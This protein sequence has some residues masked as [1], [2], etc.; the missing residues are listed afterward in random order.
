MNALRVVAIMGLAFALAAAPVHHAP[1][2]KPQ[3][4]V[5]IVINGAPL[6]L[7]PRPLL[8]NG[9]LL[10]PVQRTI[11]AL[12]LDFEREG[13]RMI[14]HVGSKTVTLRDRSRIALVN[15]E[16]IVLDAPV[17]LLNDVFYAPLRF[18]TEVLGAQA[19]FSRRERTVTIVAQLVGRSGEG[20][21]VEGN[22]TL[23]VGTVTA[24]DVNSN[25]PTV[26][27]SF[28]G[29][30]RTIGITPNAI[31][32]MRDIA[33][34]V[35][36]PGELAD[37]HPGDYAEITI[38]KDGTVLSV[39]DAFG[40]RYGTIAATNDSEFVLQDGHVIAPDRDTQIVLNGKA[41]SFG[42]LQIGDRVS[43][44]YNVE[45]SEVLE[46][47]AERSEAPPSAQSGTASIEAVTIDATQPLRAGQKLTVTLQGTPGGAATFDVG[48]YVQNVAMTERSPGTYVG[49]YVIPR[50]ANFTGVPIVGHLRMHD[51]SAVDAQSV[52]MLSAAGTPPGITSF[53]PQQG[54]TVNAD[55]PAIYA[56][57]VSSAVGVNP[58]SIRIEVNG[59]DV[60]DD[61]LRAAN[62]V[63][64]LPRTT[65]RGRVD[66]TVRIADFAG[67]ATS[68][69]WTF[70]VRRGM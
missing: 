65:Y 61:A 48:P 40:S 8:V 38:A 54:A 3:P 41:A 39:V 16:R 57:F 59:M 66:V 55:E 17:V 30:V 52:Q 28:N 36:T 43:V 33:V 60:T 13:S 42:D 22:R 10:V 37:F 11:H 35:D 23:R 44:R 56:T 24:V 53:G 51:G 45:T 31:V 4:A 1:K 47:D 20:E 12:G 32:T 70:F 6:P 29:A 14:T 15:D 27:L 63:Q 5:G 62:F 67:N 58:S 50:S 19:T 2:A 46:I 26:T 9:I 49:T 69:S 18:F 64:Y 68:K 25:P 34:D 7:E 21:F